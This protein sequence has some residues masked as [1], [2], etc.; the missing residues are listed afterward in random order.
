MS[1]AMNEGMKESLV[2]HDTAVAE[3]STGLDSRKMAIWMFIASEVIFFTA[4]ISTY[5][6]YRGETPYGQGL[7]HLELNVAAVMTFILLMSSFTMVSALAAIRDGNIRKMRLWLIAT[8]A[9]GLVFLGSQAFEWSLLFRE[10]VF[11]ST[12]LFGATFF[13]TTGFHGSHVL[14]GVLWM[15]GVIARASKGGVTPQNNLSVEMVGLYW[16]FVDLV[17]VV[18][19]TVIYLI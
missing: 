2:S 14:V 9:L 13:T 3:T 15:I 12:N 7:G 11:P 18:L 6:R 16:H 5:L 17:W 10:G 8:A 4:L 1:T 19:F